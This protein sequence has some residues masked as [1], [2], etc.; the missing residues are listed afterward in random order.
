MPR[1][2]NCPVVSYRF[3]A[4]CAK[5]IGEGP[6]LELLEIL[7]DLGLDVTAIDSPHVQDW[8]EPFSPNWPAEYLTPDP[9]FV[10]YQSMLLRDNQGKL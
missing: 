8:P 1:K 9:F 7:L 10:E 2:I 3:L 6:H 4:R 5:W